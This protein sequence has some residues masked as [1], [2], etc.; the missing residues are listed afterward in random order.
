MKFLKCKLFIIF[1]LVIVNSIYRG[2]NGWKPLPILSW[3]VGIEYKNICPKVKIRKIPPPPH[4]ELYITIMRTNITHYHRLGISNKL[5]WNYTTYSGL[6][7]V[8]N[9]IRIMFDNI[10]FDI[11]DTKAWSNAATFIG[12]REI[13]SSL[14]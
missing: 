12:R 8:N 11:I 3:V 13:S 4:C 7:Y 2:K 1:P 5:V 6:C 14:T 9:H 10:P